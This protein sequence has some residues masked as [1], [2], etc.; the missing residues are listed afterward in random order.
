[1]DQYN[2]VLYILEES[3]CGKVKVNG[4]E[5]FVDRMKLEKKPKSR[6]SKHMVKE[7]KSLRQL[8]CEN[9]KC[10][11]LH[12]KVQVRGLIENIDDFLYQA[13]GVRKTSL[14]L[15]IRQ[16]LRVQLK[17]IEIT[18]DCSNTLLELQGSPCSYDNSYMTAANKLSNFLSSCEGPRTNYDNWTVCSKTIWYALQ[19]NRWLVILGDPGSAKTTLLRWI[20]RVF[21]EAAYHSEED[22]LTPQK[23]KVVI[24]KRFNSIGRCM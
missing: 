17:C 23:S 13:C 12:F 20:T 6:M 14:S 4:Y 15:K 3:N 8:V 19:C 7:R 5:H 9:Q 1:M 21:A 18:F 16:R 11:S 2:D 24:K 10:I 22:I